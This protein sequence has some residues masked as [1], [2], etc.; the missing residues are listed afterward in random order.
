MKFHPPKKLF[1]WAYRKILFRRVGGVLLLL[2]TTGRKTGKPHTIGLQYELID[3]RYYLGA[4]DGTRA[5]W[6]RNI[7]TNPAVKIQVGA[8]VFAA[9]AEAVCDKGRIADFLQYRLNKRPFMIGLI[10]RLDGV[11]GKLNRTALENYSK[12]VGLVILTPE[13]S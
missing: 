11:K 9:S 2:T 4:A 8:N 10:L 3:G 1:A 13:S 7:L 5:D 12:K 6:Y